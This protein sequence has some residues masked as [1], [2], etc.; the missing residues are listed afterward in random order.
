MSL[1]RI[2]V[3]IASAL[4]L[5]TVAIVASQVRNTSSVAVAVEG[6]TEGDVA[7]ELAEL[8]PRLEVPS[9]P[10]SPT[11]I[12]S[13]TPGPTPTAVAP[14][15]FIEIP[16]D[17][18]ATPTP[19]EPEK[20]PLP[21]VANVPSAPRDGSVIYLTFD[22]GPNPTSTNQVLDVLARYNAKATFFVI[23]N[24]VDAYPGTVA[25]IAAEGHALGNHTYFHEALP[26]QSAEDVVQSL[27]ATNNAIARATGRT[28]GCVRPPYG[29]LDQPTLD[30]IRGQGFA[31][32]M[33]EVD[34]EDWRG[35]DAY[36][37]A[38]RVLTDVRLGSRVLFHD[39]PT[40]RATTVA[41]LESVL[42]VLS[43]RGV[44]FHP[45]PSC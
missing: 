18:I 5:L 34:S 23:G 9:P 35:G 38:S 2:A 1:R 31:V 29:S 3:V 16:E 21:I 40:N 43:P 45:L 24:S 41:A 13:P 4:L 44:Q 6:D 19:V 33:W 11:P 22:D 36:T 17:L 39:G 30:V 20:V 7:D 25:R 8:Q 14:P 12:P 42:E 32:S 10:P 26:Q 15:A 37:I 27:A 28:S